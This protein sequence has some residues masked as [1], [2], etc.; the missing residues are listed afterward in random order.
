MSSC[1]GGGTPADREQ[2]AILPPIM[3]ELASAGPSS[4][5]SWG[6]EPGDRIRVEFAGPEEGQIVSFLIQCGGLVAAGGPG[7]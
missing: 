3:Q 7:E 5:H 4:I 2:H 6:P 1:A